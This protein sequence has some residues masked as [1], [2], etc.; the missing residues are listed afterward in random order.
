MVFSVH[1]TYPKTY[2]NCAVPT[3]TEGHVRGVALKN[4][5][6]FRG[7]V[8]ARHCSSGSD[9]SGDAEAIVISG[10]VIARLYCTSERDSPAKT[11][12]V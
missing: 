4:V 3:K 1:A 9:K 12:T 8:I 10:I 5:R 2:L 7:I 11:L 6:I